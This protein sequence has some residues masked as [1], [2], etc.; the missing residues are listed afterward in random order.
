MSTATVQG[1]K[2]SQMGAATLPLDGDELV[3][4]VQDGIN[5]YTPAGTLGGS[6]SGAV[7]WTALI[8]AALA[9]GANNNLAPAGLDAAARL[10][11]TPVDDTSELRGLAAGTDGQM[12]MI[13]N[14]S[15]AF[16]FTVV[17][18]SG[19]STAANRF[20]INGDLIIPPRCGAL[21]QY[22]GTVDR[23]VKA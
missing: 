21:F 16:L 15:V 13:P 23:W 14:H 8:S 10:G 17:N 20:A 3:P 7:V 9:A 5:R 12:L 6:P 2:I 1:V 19:T 22:D 18:E 4:V 11:L